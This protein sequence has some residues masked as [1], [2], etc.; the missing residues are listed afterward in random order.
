MTHSTL[1]GKLRSRAAQHPQRRALTFLGEGET[2]SATL[3]YAALD[4]RAPSPPKFRRGPNRARASCCCCRR[5][6]ITSRR[7]GVAFTPPPPPRSIRLARI[8]PTNG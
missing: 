6:W 8:A 3:T 7:L 5:A 4:A 1:V 2:E